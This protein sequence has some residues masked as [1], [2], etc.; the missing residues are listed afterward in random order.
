[1]LS[2][3]LNSEY[4]TQDGIQ[5]LLEG[6]KD[7]GCRYIYYDP[8]VDQYLM[9]VNEPVYKDGE[10]LACVGNRIAITNFFLIDVLSDIIRD[11]YIDILDYIDETDWS[12]VPVDAK[13]L[14]ETDGF[15]YIHNYFAKYENGKVYV[16]ANGRTSWSAAGEDYVISLS[17][18]TVHLA[19]DE[20]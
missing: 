3:K 20:D 2:S 14:E 11:E 12:K 7:A 16:W 8:E 10:F 13:V 4:L 9:S 17:P 19:K 15:G 6:I 5:L 18:K 1:M